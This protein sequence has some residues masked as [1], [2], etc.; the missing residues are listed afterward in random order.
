MTA[1]IDRLP[2]EEKQLLQAV[3]VIN[4]DH[5][6]VTNLTTASAG[7]VEPCGFRTETCPPGMK[8][9]DAIS[10]PGGYVGGGLQLQ[11]DP[12]IGPAGEVWVI[13]NW[14][15]P[16]AAL[17]TVDE[18]QQTLGQGVVVFYAMAKPVKAPLIG[19][20]RPAP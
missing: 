13:I 5:A 3:S 17:G 20:P 7:L 4:N 19:P 8:T 12:Q 11:V 9:G 18:A 2:T 15:Y 6:W 10:P 14:Q 16:P 1:R